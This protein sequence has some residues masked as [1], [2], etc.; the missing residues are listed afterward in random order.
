VT[1]LMCCHD[2][3]SLNVGPVEDRASDPVWLQDLRVIP[4]WSDLAI[5]GKMVRGRGRKFEHLFL[6][7]GWL[8]SFTEDELERAAES[9]AS[10]QAK[11]LKGYTNMVMAFKNHV[12]QGYHKPQSERTA[13]PQSDA[14]PKGG[15]R[16]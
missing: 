8:T 14:R 5:N 1:D 11:T 9:F 3:G 6:R 15:G 2:C 16:Y 10:T 12:A 7:R 4:G 13:A